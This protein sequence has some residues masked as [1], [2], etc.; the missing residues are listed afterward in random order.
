MTKQRRERI[1]RDKKWAQLSKELRTIT[2]HCQL[3]GRTDRLQVHHILSR[4]TYKDIMYEVDN[5]IVVCPSCHKYGPTSMHHN[6]VAS[7][8][9]LQKFCPDKYTWVMNY[10]L[11]KGI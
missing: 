7:T 9:L 8:Y 3:C 5:L 6:S 11:N 2:P 1:E 10:L 4:R